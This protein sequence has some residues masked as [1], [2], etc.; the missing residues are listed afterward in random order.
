MLV[1]Q[2]LLALT[3][4]AF[5][6]APAWP[7]AYVHRAVAGL[8]SAG[9]LPELATLL[10]GGPGL[11]VVA[12]TIGVAFW[13]PLPVAACLLLLG[14][15]S[16][17][18]IQ[19][20]GGAPVRDVPVWMC[21]EEVGAEISRYPA[22]SFYLPFKRAFQGIYPS[23]QVRAPAFPG[24]LRRAFDLDSWFYLP[25]ARAVEDGAR[26]VSRTHVG[27]PQVYLLWIVVGAIAVIGIVLAA[28]S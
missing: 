7:L 15:A 26:G 28:V 20:A 12:G 10:G 25:V 18:L 6:L 17:F 16:Y 5:G 23:V 21:G 4:V 9:S 1:P 3:C 2:A 13:A 19:R 27:I 24:W 11:R 8:P 14:A 22:S